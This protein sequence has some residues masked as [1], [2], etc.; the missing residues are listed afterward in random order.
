MRCLIVEIVAQRAD[1]RPETGLYIRGGGIVLSGSMSYI[2]ICS[3]DCRKTYYRIVEHSNSRKKKSIVAICVDC[4]RTF[5]NVYNGRGARCD[6]CQ[7]QFDI[8][9]RRR[10]RRKVKAQRRIFKYNTRKQVFNSYD[11]VCPK[12]NRKTSDELKT[13][14]GQYP[15]LDHIVPISKGGKD[16]KGNLRLLCRDCNSLKRNKLDGEWEHGITWGRSEQ[17]RA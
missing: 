2:P 15:N 11:R 7:A 10:S 12:C 17:R 6:L 9:T 4:G 13:T 14:D 8:E 5:P 1:M 16:D 3:H